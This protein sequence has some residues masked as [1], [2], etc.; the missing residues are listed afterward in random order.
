MSAVL[1]R[2]GPVWRCVVCFVGYAARVTCRSGASAWF[3]AMTSPKCVEDSA[4]MRTGCELGEVFKS[5]SNEG[6][7]LVR[8]SAICGSP[9]L[10][11]ARARGQRLVQVWK[12]VV[13]EV[14]QLDFRV[15]APTCLVHHP[16]SDRLASA[17]GAGA[18]EDDADAG[19]G[20]TCEPAPRSRRMDCMIMNVVL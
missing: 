3:R 20:W 5:V 1:F 11:M 12:R 17:P 16:A 18:S 10:V 14:D 13:G 2:Q 7:T 15:A 19:H 6:A 9:A 4:L 8:M